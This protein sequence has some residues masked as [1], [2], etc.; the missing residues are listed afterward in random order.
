MLVESAAVFVQLATGVG[1]VL[2]GVGH[3]TVVKPLA[4]DGPAGVQD[5]TGVLNV[6]VPV[7]VTFT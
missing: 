5:G 2:T 7:Q 3:V 4:A 6:E 1:G